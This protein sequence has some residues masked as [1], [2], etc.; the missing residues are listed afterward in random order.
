MQTE[1][2]TN[3]RPRTTRKKIGTY[4]EADKKEDQLTQ[5]ISENR[6]IFAL[7]QM[8]NNLVVYVKYIVSIV[9]TCNDDFFV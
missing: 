7:R 9:E 4:A 3:V 1:G 6:E 2:T 5:T 8:L